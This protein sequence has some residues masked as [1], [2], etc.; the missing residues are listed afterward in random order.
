MLES[1][2]EIRKLERDGFNRET[3][4]KQMYKATDGMSTP[5]RRKLVQKLYQ[6][7]DC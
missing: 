6:R 1:V 5:E 3:I 7:G 2:G 4:T